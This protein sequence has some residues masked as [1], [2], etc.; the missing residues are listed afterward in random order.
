MPMLDKNGLTEAEFLS[1]Y[2]SDRY[3]KPSLTADVVMLTRGQDM[4]VLLICRGGHPCIGMYAFPGGFAEASESIEQTALR[5]LRE[6]TGIETAELLPVGLFS[7]PGRDKRGWVVSQCFVSL[8]PETVAARAG[9]DATR[10]EWFRLGLGNN[11]VNLTGI[12]T[13]ITIGYGVRDGQVYTE[14]LSE[15]KLAF[16]HA[17][18]LV[19]A[20]ICIQKIQI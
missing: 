16:D 15:D 6:E 14:S 4:R 10:A 9:D 11:T 3:P 19:R 13:Q 17:D 12:Q 18:M 5:E 2:N 1:G 7:T 8:L 20:L